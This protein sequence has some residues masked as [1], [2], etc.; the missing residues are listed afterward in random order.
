M[1][2]FKKTENHSFSEPIL[3]WTQQ[4]IDCYNRKCICTGC[5]INENLETPCQL[6]AI[7]PKIFAKCGKPPKEIKSIVPQ[8]R[9]YERNKEN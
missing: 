8:V 9:K 5:F 6:K 1:A 2:N 3:K 4:A 7:I